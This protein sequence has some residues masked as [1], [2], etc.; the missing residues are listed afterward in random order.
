V[1]RV[2]VAL[3]GRLVERDKLLLEFATI[4]DAISCAVAIER[5]MLMANAAIP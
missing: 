2:F 1:A 3:H 4:A 5:G